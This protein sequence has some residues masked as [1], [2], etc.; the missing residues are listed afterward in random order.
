MFTTRHITTILLIGVGATAVLD[1]WLLVLK[2]LGVP[3]GGFAP[4]G[5]WVAHMMRGRFRHVS[6]AKA[7]PV[8]HEGAIGWATHYAVGIAFAVVLVALQGAGWVEQPTF[9]PAF[10]TGLA[11][12]A[13]PLL[14]MQPAMGSGFAASRTP[15]PLKNCAR[16]V[17][18]HAVFG[19]GLYLTAI[20]VAWLVR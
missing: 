8:R 7:E 10:L 16:S 19:T 15:T 5:R 12:V 2:R 18:N 20:A 11:T 9:L 13:M 4:V 17:A 3:T 1:L 6:I 14:V